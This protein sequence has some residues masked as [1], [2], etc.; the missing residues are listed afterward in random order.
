MAIKSN[1]KSQ[2]RVIK[3]A[4]CLSSIN[5]AAKNGFFPLVKQLRESEKLYQCYGV[6]QNRITK[7]IE[8]SD[9]YSGYRQYV[10]YYSYNDIDWELVIPFTDHYPFEYR[11]ECPFAAYLIPKDLTTGERV[12]LEDLIE[13][14]RAGKFWNRNIRL[15]SC[16]AIW[17]GKNL[18]VQYDPEIHDVCH[19]IG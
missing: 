8:V 12:L 4:R 1:E 2:L 17:D 19:W 6:F 18:V 16:E 11:F 10:E 15:E 7:E 14:Y 13:D 3:T 9:S 5:A